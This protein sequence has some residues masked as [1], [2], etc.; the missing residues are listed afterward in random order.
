MTTNKKTITKMTKRQKFEA[1][2]KISAVAEN[3]MLVEFIN[4]ELELLTKK[5]STEKKPTSTQ[6]VN[7]GL[8]DV[9]YATLTATEGM[10]TITD[11]IK[12]IPELAELSNQKVASLVRQLK[13]ENKVERIMDK[14]KA[15]FKAVED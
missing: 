13:D 10:M 7:E 14:R 5:N 12:T 4:H 8:K 15:Y 3:E 9:I 1:L 6:V 11:M 2:L